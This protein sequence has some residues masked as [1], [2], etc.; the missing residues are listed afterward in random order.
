MKTG[1][2]ISPVIVTCKSCQHEFK[3][4]LG[5]T[6]LLIACHKCGQL[7]ANDPDGL[8]PIHQ[9]VKRPVAKVIIVPIGSKGTFFNETYTV[10]GF[11]CKK[12][13]G[14][15]YFWNEYTLYNP[16]K[17]CIY[18]S[19]FNGH[20]MVLQELQ[21]PLKDASSSLIYESEQYEL[22]AS[23]K[24]ITHYWVGEFIYDDSSLK[25]EWV[26]EY[27]APPY[28][29]CFENDSCNLSFYKAEYLLPKTI[30]D[31]FG[32]Q[33]IP[34]RAG[35]GM[36]EPFADSSTLKWM[37]RLSFIFTFIWL[38]IV[39]VT[40]NRSKDQVIFSNAYSI[41]DSMRQKEFT[42][43]TFTITNANRN[44]K[45]EI[46][47][48]VSNA[49]L[50]ANLTLVN[51]TTGDIYS[52]DLEGEYYSGVT[53]GESWAEGSRVAYTII[54]NVEKGV[55]Y[56]S[57]YPDKADNKIPAKLQITLRSD[58]FILSNAFIVFLLAAIYPVIF[59]IRRYYFEKGRW[60]NSDYSPYSYHN[61]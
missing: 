35:V 33:E 51:Q 45:I 16:L 36:I 52:T 54:P 39:I 47:C 12:E 21:G 32:L 49:W 27:I 24:S 31:T 50:Y 34:S 20:W 48:D 30:A 40:G 43:Q 17:G 22:F 44:V 14:T 60:E 42:T 56:L 9:K 18:L 29:I 7:H 61:D 59:F 19:E 58:V 55:Y 53:E 11:K 28:A 26:K 13:E 10:I 46:D 3:T 6:A 4:L 8:K 15:S 1:L 38:L 37:T 5:H 41:E 25:R 23:Y 2:S 57:I